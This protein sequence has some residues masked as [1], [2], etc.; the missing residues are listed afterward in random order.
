MLEVEGGT[1]DWC[2]RFCVMRPGMRRQRLSASCPLA[3]SQL[4]GSWHAPYPDSYR[5]GPNTKRFVIHLDMWYAQAHPAEDFAETFAVWLNPQSRWEQQYASWPAITKLRYVDSLMRRLID[6]PA[7]ARSPA[8]HTLPTLR[9]TFREHYEAK[10]PQCL[11]RQPRD[12][13]S[14]PAAYFF[15]TTPTL[16]GANRRPPFL[17]DIAPEARMMVS[18][19][20]AGAP[21]TINRSIADME[22]RV[23]VMGLR[24]RKTPRQTKLDVM[25]MLAVQTM[26]FVNDGKHRVNL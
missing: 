26:N 18:R 1:P 20:T 7:R 3:I 12:P 23:E 10:A 24:L 2:M 17:R 6:G 5:P 14:R 9:K 25:M 8:T 16:P 11:P 22:N 21:L 4:F 15:R 13:R 19:W